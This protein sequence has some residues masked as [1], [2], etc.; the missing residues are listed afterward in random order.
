MSS[1]R[2]LSAHVQQ[3]QHQQQQYENEHM[4]TLHA[5]LHQEAD[6]IRKWKIQT[7]LDLK[8]KVCEMCFSFSTFLSLTT[9]KKC[10]A[11]SSVIF[12]CIAV[13]SIMEMCIWLYRRRIA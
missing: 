7:E 4:G 9:I 12:A 13:I 6:K 3:Q 11:Y 1:Q 8:D 5:R 10:R 2:T